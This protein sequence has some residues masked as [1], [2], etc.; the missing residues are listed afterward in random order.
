MKNAVQG[1]L[2]DDMKPHS[3]HNTVPVHGDDLKA[4]EA[5]A[6]SQD[7]MIIR[8]FKEHPYTSFTPD[9]VWLSFGQQWPITSVRRAITNATKDGHLI[10][11]GER[12]MGLYGMNTNTWIYKKK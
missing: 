8:Y 9:Q 5:K 11:T 12:R 4:A 7:D 10:V 6:A 1:T 2:F 3:Y